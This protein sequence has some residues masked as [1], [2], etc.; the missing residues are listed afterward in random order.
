MPPAYPA[1]MPGHGPSLLA[2]LLDEQRDLEGRI[3]ELQTS[4]AET[5]AVGGALLAFAA[6]EDEAFSALAPLLDPAV[7]AEMTAEHEQFAE[8]LDLLEWLL[9]TTPASPDVPVLTASLIRRMRQHIDRDGRLLA[10][11]AALHS[12][13]SESRTA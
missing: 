1:P 13:A 12:R 10:R 9:R 8:D 4:P 11:A 3:H 7:H 5:L 6:R 2:A